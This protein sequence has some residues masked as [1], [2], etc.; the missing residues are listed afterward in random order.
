V[1]PVAFH[2]LGQLGVARFL[3]EI[4][5]VGFDSIEAGVHLR[6]HRSHQ[7]ALGARKP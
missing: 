2:L 4:L 3:T 5:S 6:D 1:A 7:L